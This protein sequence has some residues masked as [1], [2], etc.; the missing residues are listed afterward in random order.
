MIYVISETSDNYEFNSV[1]LMGF[2]QGVQPMR[3]RDLQRRTGGTSL[4][5][6]PALSR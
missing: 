6:Y 2:I 1:G 5:D 3:K 4:R